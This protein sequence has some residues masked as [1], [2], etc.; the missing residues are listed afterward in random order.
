MCMNS[1]RNKGFTLVELIIFIVVVAAGMAGILSVMNT[2]VAASADPMANKQALA[3]AESLLEEILQKPLLDPDGSPAGE[4]DRSNWDN[5]ADYNGYPAIAGPVSDVFGV[6]VPGLGAYSI[7]PPVQVTA[8]VAA[9]N[10]ALAAVGALRVSVSVTW[11]SR[12][13]TLVGYRAP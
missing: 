10:T 2:T 1:L 7:A 13:V 6:A 8:A 5:V 4:T 12:V 9:N 3:I 11:G